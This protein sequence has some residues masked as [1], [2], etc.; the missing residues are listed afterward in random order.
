MMK[1]VG[2]LLAVQL[3]SFVHGVRQRCQRHGG[4]FA[5]QVRQ[6]IGR[7]VELRGVLTH[8][9]KPLPLVLAPHLDYAYMRTFAQHYMCIYIY[10]VYIYY[11]YIYICLSKLHHATFLHH[12]P[13]CPT[14]KQCVGRE[15]SGN[16]RDCISF[17]WA[18]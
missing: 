13:I 18:N 7:C 17:F 14:R 11:V 1:D 6:T 12:A 5:C 4:I 8:L 3:M 16:G 15:V 2:L 10:Y 9:A